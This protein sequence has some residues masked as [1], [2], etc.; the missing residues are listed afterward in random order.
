M[1]KPQYGSIIAFD[2]KKIPE[3]SNF[4]S[5]RGPKGGFM[6]LRDPILN[7]HKKTN[8]I[9]NIFAKFGDILMITLKIIKLLSL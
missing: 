2:L 3:N 9:P 4:E 6:G 7:F 8:R 5:Q 1:K